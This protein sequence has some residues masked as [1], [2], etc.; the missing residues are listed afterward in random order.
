MQVSRGAGNPTVSTLESTRSSL[1][2]PITAEISDEMFALLERC[3]GTRTV[4]EIVDASAL[5]RRAN[6]SSLDAELVDLWSARMIVLRP[7]AVRGVL[8]DDETRA[9][10][11]LR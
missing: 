3:D 7:R 6:L 9:L 2:G 10:L 4:D 8:E 1:F 11:A 5:R